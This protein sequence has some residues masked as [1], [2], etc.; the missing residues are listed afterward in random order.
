[1]N[2]DLHTHSKYSDGKETPEELI[3]KAKQFEIDLISITDHDTIG[4]LDEAIV[5]SEKEGIKFVTGVEL[6]TNYEINGTTYYLHLLGYKFDNKEKELNEKLNQLR[7]NRSE[8]VDKTFE[9]LNEILL[10]ENKP[11]IPLEELNEMKKT[12]DSIGK[13]HLAH[14]LVNNEIVNNVDEGFDLYLKKIR[15]PKKTLSLEEGS[16]LIRNAGGITVLAH[17]WCSN[18]YPLLS[19]TRNLNEQIKLLEEMK[20]SLDGIECF[21]WDHGKANCKK[22][23]KIAK[24]LDL[25]VTGG[26][27]HHGFDHYERLGKFTDPDYVANF[28]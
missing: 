13:S 23:A 14:L 5:T 12:T 19:I 21:Y 20:P 26:S 24:H 9:K 3:K 15:V 17:P 25:I 6:T 28:F 16:K 18:S 1:M 8:K 4:G 11:L 27:D 22:Y 10:F 2:I 7:D